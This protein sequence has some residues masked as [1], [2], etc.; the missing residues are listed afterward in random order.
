MTG[1]T[2]F[3]KI[4]TAVYEAA[5]VVNARYRD[6]VLNLQAMSLTYTTLL[7]LVP[8]LAVMFRRASLGRGGARYLSWSIE[9]RQYS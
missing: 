4:R 9:H 5:A 1:R 7:S 2:I 8:F 3:S 6:D